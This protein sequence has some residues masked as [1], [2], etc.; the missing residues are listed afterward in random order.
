ME[1]FGFCRRTVFGKD[2]VGVGRRGSWW[3]DGE[4]NWWVGFGGNVFTS[5]GF[6]K[7]IGDLTITVSVFV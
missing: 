2:I 7:G 6:R 5:K 3:F 1:G 4:L